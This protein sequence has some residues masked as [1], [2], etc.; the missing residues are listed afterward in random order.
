MIPN[1]MSEKKGNEKYTIYLSK[2]NSLK[3]LRKKISRCLQRLHKDNNLSI[4]QSE[5]S[6]KFWKLDP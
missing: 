3:Q 2:Q 4:N 1:I 5:S 6:Y